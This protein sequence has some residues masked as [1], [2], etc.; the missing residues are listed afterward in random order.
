MD[1]VGF[2]RAPTDRDRQL[3]MGRNPKSEGRRDVT[4]EICCD[5]TYRVVT[6]VGIS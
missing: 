5:F 1:G 4:M 3:G 2:A 6:L